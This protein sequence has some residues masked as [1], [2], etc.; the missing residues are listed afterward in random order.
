MESNICVKED[1]ILVEPKESDFVEIMDSL[2]RLF[3]MPEYLNKNVIWRFRAGPLKTTYNEL[4]KLKDF[5]QNYFPDNAKSDK[6][7]AIVVE[8]GLYAAMAAEYTKIVADL[9]LNFRVFTDMKNAE[10]WIIEWDRRDNS[11]IAGNRDE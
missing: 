2:A 5:I 10:T 1:Y 8:T 4:Y 11:E 6:R 7:V 9:P 3:T